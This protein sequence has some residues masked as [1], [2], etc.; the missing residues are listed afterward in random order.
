[1]VVSL[2]AVLLLGVVVVMLCRYA[3]LRP[4]HGIICALLGFYLASSTVGPQISDAGRAVVHWL[5]G[6]HL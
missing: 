1:M 5:S 3:G 6:I 2:S 4:W